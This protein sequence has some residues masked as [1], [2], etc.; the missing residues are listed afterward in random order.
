MRYLLLLEILQQIFCIQSRGRREN[1]IFTCRIKPP[2]WRYCRGEKGFSR[3][4]ADRN[5]SNKYRK[6]ARN[7]WEN[8]KYDEQPNNANKEEVIN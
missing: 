2:T 5:I 4:I 6:L 7:R 8:Y 3:L 1:S